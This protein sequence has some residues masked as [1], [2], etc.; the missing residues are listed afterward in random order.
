MTLLLV[1]LVL[2]CDV[3]MGDVGIASRYVSSGSTALGR[4]CRRVIRFGAPDFGKGI[5]SAMSRI[6]D[7]PEA[8][9]EFR[10]VVVRFKKEVCCVAFL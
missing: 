1:V 5:D 8:D 10:R 4:F 3:S 6:N 7:K 9:M 2:V